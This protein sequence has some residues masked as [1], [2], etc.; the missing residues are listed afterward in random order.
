MASPSLLRRILED[1]SNA[2]DKLS[3]VCP[4]HLQTAYSELVEWTGR[5]I[6]ND[7]RGFISTQTPDILDRLQ[8]DPKR[9]MT[10]STQFEAM[11]RKRFNNKPKQLNTG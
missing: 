8:I 6:R 7:K 1:L 2:E 4:L 9:W 5:I 10:S 11:H 3:R